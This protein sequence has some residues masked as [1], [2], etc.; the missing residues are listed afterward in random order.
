MKSQTWTSNAD[1]ALHVCSFMGIPLLLQICAMSR[2]L[3]KLVNTNAQLWLDLYHSE[4]TEPAFACENHDWPQYLPPCTTRM[5]ALY[6]RAKVLDLFA[7]KHSRSRKLSTK[8]MLFG[9]PCAGSGSIAPPLIPRSGHTSVILQRPAR[10]NA[11]LPYPVPQL[12]LLIFF[13]G[14]GG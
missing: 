6:W 11:G 14:A 8:A 7:L 2:G 5:T 10:E 3:R 12:D 13:G 1:V 4:V 9:P